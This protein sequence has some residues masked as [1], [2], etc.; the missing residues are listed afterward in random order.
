V[1][2]AAFALLLGGG[3]QARGQL[4]PVPLPEPLARIAFTAGDGDDVY[5]IAADGSG[6]TRLTRAAAGQTNAEPAWS[7]DGSQIAFSRFTEDPDDD[8]ESEERGQVWLMRPDGGDQRPLAPAPP[9][10]V[11]ESAPAWS[12]DGRMLA[13]ERFRIG[14]SRI[15]SSIVVV[16]ADGSG[17]RT[18]VREI[19]AGLTFVGEPAWSPD[20]GSILY[21]RTRLDSS[22]HFRPSL[23]VV[24]A[25]G[26]EPRVLARDAGQGAWSPDG[27]RIAF[28]SVR[29]RNG[30]SCGSDECSYAGEIYVMGADG[31]GPV[32]LT[33]SKGGDGAPAWSPDGERIAFHS[34]RNY[35]D[36]ERPELYSMRP[37][38][39]C[40]TWLT[41][42]TA[43]S[44]TPD[45]EPGA[46]R[47]SDPGACGATPR[48][49]LVET[50][51]TPVTSY[52][53][54]PVYWL[55]R[56]TD[57]GLL[58]SD[59]QAEGGVSLT[60]DDCGR[61]EPSACPKPLSVGN[62]STCGK[63]DGI[64][65]LGGH[66]PSRITLLGEA[67]LYRPK[68][69]YEIGPE[70]YTGPTTVSVD[71]AGAGSLTAIL[72]KLRR[73]NPEGEPGRFPR[74]AFPLRF[75]RPIERTSAAY[76]KYG[77]IGAVNRRLHYSRFDVREYLAIGKRLR[78]LGRFGRLDCQ[79][80]QAAGL[81]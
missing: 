52:T 45:W 23:H 65:D 78:R 71:G 43:W 62:V 21:T 26:G 75:W 13:I 1:A 14:S 7:P 53:R 8:D 29:D 28:A 70:L 31:S 22:A 18:L 32:R 9:A 47:S 49:P 63:P 56:S 12:P 10:G 81:D 66:Q 48:E 4:P 54:I 46:G 19:A 79:R 27:A 33:R 36:G 17:R 77:T 69:D 59:V 16:A 55:G 37:D 57:D 72:R 34:D 30:E 2:L 61:F 15:V 68:F 67:I 76:R 25:A 60:Y 44:G 51:A 40:L 80:R 24:S 73:A 11:I 5:A 35:P 20:G 38:G 64:L 42:G 50:D 41:N 58:L 3:G 74:A 39:T 6:R